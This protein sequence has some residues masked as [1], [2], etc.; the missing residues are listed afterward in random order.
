M[1]KERDRL[2]TQRVYTGTDLLTHCLRACDRLYS[3]LTYVRL[4][5]CSFWWRSLQD[6]QWN[7]SIA[8]SPP[9]HH[10]LRMDSVT[11]LSEYST[12]TDKMQLL[13]AL[14]LPYTAQSVF[15][16][17]TSCLWKNLS[18]FIF[19]GEWLTVNNWPILMIFGVC[20]I[21]RKFNIQSL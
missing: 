5:S 10:S 13:P 20:E 15:D 1:G 9:T 14:L 19:F 3:H 8:R 4:Y 17:T 12:C 6:S 21:L 7:I 16:E 11:Q 18:T 2:K